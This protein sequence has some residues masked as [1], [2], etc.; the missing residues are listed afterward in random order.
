[1]QVLRRKT[2]IRSLQVIA[3]PDVMPPNQVSSERKVRSYAATP[4]LPKRSDC[5]A[6]FSS[7]LPERI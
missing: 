5:F 7:Q 6:L 3:E 2:K 1:V 4:Q